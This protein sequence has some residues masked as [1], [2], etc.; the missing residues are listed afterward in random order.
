FSSR[1]RH[2]RSKRDWSSDVCSSD[3]GNYGIVNQAL[4]AIGLPQP[5]WTTDRD[6]KFTSILLVDLWMWTPFMLLISL[7]ALNAIPKSIA[8]E[9]GRASCRK[10]CCCR[11]WGASAQKT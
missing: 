6:W 1:R 5:Q 9:I 3:L 4:G 8:A 7:A 2:T 11:R 10:E